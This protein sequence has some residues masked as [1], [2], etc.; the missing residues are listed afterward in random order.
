MS[1]PLEAAASPAGLDASCPRLTV[2]R[3]RIRA[4]AAH[5]RAPERGGAYSF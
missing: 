3:R 1:F 4:R 2:F 5:Q